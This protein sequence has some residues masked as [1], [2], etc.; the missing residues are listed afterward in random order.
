MERNY[1]YI[2]DNSSASR[3]LALDGWLLERRVGDDDLI[4]YFYVNRSAVIIGKNQNPRKEC[5]IQ[6]MRRDGVELVR[7]LSGG[8]AVYHDSG[9]LNFSFIAGKNRF[10][11][12]RQHIFILNCIRSLGI[13]C[14]FSGRNDLLAGGR[15]FSGNAYTSKGSAKQHHGT[16]LVDS[17][18]DKL[19]DYLTVDE[20]KLRSKGVDSVRSRVCNLKELSPA[21]TPERLLETIK[22]KFKEEYGDF[23]ELSFNEAEQEEI[24]KYGKNTLCFALVPEHITGKLVTES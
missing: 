9:N 1:I 17:S 14:T 10:D 15:K 22:A 12:M 3:N 18:L 23:E 20:R 21:L 4:L 6:K 16:L 11:K 2:S 19:M 5:D 24:E 7:R 8:G 13:D